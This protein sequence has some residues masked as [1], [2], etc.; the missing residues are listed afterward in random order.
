MSFDEDEEK[1]PFSFKK[2]VSKS[3]TTTFGLPNAEPILNT[4]QLDNFDLLDDIKVSNS[5]KKTQNPFSFKR[6]INTDQPPL[7]ANE[8]PSPPSFDLYTASNLSNSSPPEFLNESLLIGN[9]L[10][11]S[12]SELA[13]LNSISKEDENIFE[14]SSKNTSKQI[15]QPE[16]FEIERL[17]LAE[18][19][20][21][22]HTMEEMLQ[23]K[24]AKQTERIAELENKI[25]K[26]KQNEANENRALESIIQQVEENLVKTTKRAVE[27]E[28]NAEKMRH[29]IKQL[30]VE[31][32]LLRSTCGSQPLHEYAGQL[33]SAATSADSSLKQLL[34]GCETLRL[35]AASLDS[36]GKITEINEG[37]E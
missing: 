11:K 34:A 10:V 13:F 9:D 33:R 20:L 12:E 29:E 17:S 3:K 7:S 21:K 30:K 32:Q 14:L 2:F 4:T 26:L 24:V 27:S 1:N 25:K 23:R 31:N 19:T 36:F 18:D 35:V 16:Q 28:R 15:P 8:I 22:P 5:A 37:Q 6:F